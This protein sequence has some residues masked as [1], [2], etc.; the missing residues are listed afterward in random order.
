MKN[1]LSKLKIYGLFATVFSLI[2]FIWFSS[3]CGMLGTFHW[4]LFY[5]SIYILL[6]IFLIC[7]FISVALNFFLNIKFVKF[8]L[9]F[10]STL[11]IVIWLAWFVALNALTSIPVDN[12][13]LNLFSQKQEIP[14][15]P[16][17]TADDPILHLAFSSDPHWGSSKSN[18]EARTKIL[19]QIDSKDYDAFFILGDLTEMGML[20]GD[21]KLAVADLRDYLKNTTFRP[22]PGNHDAILNGIKIFNSIFMK[23]GEKHYYRMDKDSVHLLFINMLWD[24]TEFTKKQQK[25][26]EKQLKSIPQEDTVIV[27]SHCYTLSSGYYDENA[28]KNWGDLPDVMKKLSPILEK[29]NV[30]LSMSGHEHFYEYLE[31]DDVP[32]LVLGTMGGALD[33]NLIYHSPY[34]KWLDNEHFGYVDMKIYDSYLT[35][36]C[37]TENGEI[38]YS[39]RIVT[40]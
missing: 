2:L 24:T 40:K 29:Y 16:G 20:A 11:N 9:G 32:Y 28:K 15:K 35:F 12:S 3:I 14:S 8:L 27:L 5:R 4:H 36:D 30:D 18:N 38:L 22:I 26:L 39:D 31:K 13:G 25:W 34:S 37:I 6:I 21:Y 17:K 19:K 23:K 1:T 33:E 7:Q 10:F